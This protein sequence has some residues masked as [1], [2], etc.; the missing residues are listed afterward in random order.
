LAI[1]SLRS[2]ILA[3]Y[4]LPLNGALGAHGVVSIMEFLKKLPRY[5]FENS[6]QE[7]HGVIVVLICTVMFWVLFNVTDLI[8]RV[9]D[10]RFFINYELAGCF[11]GC[12]GASEL[13]RGLTKIYLVKPDKLKPVIGSAIAGAT[14][15]F[16]YGY[17]IML[18]WSYGAESLILFTLAG[19]SVYLLLHW[20]LYLETKKQEGT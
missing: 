3:N 11:V 8:L 7:F 20:L 12:F 9:F 4:Y 5:C 1:C 18:K 19:A 13:V 16:I 15:G 17:L 6:R 14:F 10:W 2:P